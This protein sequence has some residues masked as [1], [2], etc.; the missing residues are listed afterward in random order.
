MDDFLC[1]DLQTRMLPNQPR[2]N[3]PPLNKN[4][5]LSLLSEVKLTASRYSNEVSP[6]D[7]RLSVWPATRLQPSLHMEHN[8]WNEEEKKVHSGK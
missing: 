5:F 1:C 4:E 2:C 6:N 3:G 8:L 7:F